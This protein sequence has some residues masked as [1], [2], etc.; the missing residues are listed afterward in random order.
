LCIYYERYSL[1]RNHLYVANG[2]TLYNDIAIGM[3]E[4]NGLL[5]ETGEIM[6]DLVDMPLKIV[7]KVI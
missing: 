7:T 1:T 3:A 5:M 2:T 6:T 4:M